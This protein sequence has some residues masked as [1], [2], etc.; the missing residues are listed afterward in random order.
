MELYVVSRRYSCGIYPTN[1]DVRQ[2]N[3]RCIPHGSSMDKE[4]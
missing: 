1:T 3:V 4:V 2:L